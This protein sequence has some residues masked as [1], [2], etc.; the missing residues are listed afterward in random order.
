MKTSN[1]LMVGDLLAESQ[2]ATCGPSLAKDKKAPTPIPRYVTANGSI[3]YMPGAGLRSKLRGALTALTLEALEKRGARR[4]GLKDAQFN[5]VGGI[6]QGGSESAKGALER[7]AMVRANP[8]L[9]LFGASTPWVKGAAMVGHVSCRS[10]TLSAMHVEGVRSDIFRREP[11]LME[12]LNDDAVAEYNAQTERTKAYS[13]LK[14]EMEALTKV[15]K[16]RDKSITADERSAA[17][18]RLK[19][20]DEEAKKSKTVAAQQPLQGYEAIPPGAHLDNKISLVG[21]TEI[22]LGAMVAAMARFAEA[23]VLGAHSAHGAGV[24]SGTWQVSKTG[25]GQIGTLRIEPFMGL[26]IE[27]DKLLAAKAA[28]E[29]FVVTDECQP[30]ALDDADQVTDPDTEEATE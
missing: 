22:E 3:M 18:A 30:Y 14:K 29:A 25:E 17:S 26:V 23:P 6:K 24:I 8:V 11:G 5:R 27:G 1:Y 16:S 13:L 19:V 4:F 20:L 9:G 28:F 12:F 21:A 7:L 2:L 10:A 15:A